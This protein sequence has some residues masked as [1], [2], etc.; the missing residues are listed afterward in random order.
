MKIVKIMIAGLGLLA[1]SA[2]AQ[3]PAT[4]PAV[5]TEMSCDDF[6]PTTEAQQ[7]FAE[8]EGACEAIVERGGVLY[9]KTTAIVRRSTAGSVRLYL[10]S[11]D[12]TFTVRP[13][14]D[15]Y[16]LAAGVKTRPRDLVR[17]QEVRIYISVEEFG[18]PVIEEIALVTETDEI[19][20]R[21]VE[22]VPAL[23]TTASMLPALGLAGG[24]LLLGAGL[25][26]RVRTRRS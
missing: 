3:D 17:G 12:H 6:T 5:P 20:V 21:V 9:A 8:L 14:S 16:V 11:T 18:Q 4:S 26:R 23:P 1:F 15:T 19:V 10:P 25:I 24:L 2:L 22:E 13:G 7:R